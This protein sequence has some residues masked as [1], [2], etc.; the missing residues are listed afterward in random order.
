MPASNYL[1]GT[2]PD[3]VPSNAD[4]GEMA[5]QSKDAVEF[6]GG[7]GGLS[8]LDITAISAQ[9]NVTATDVFVYDTSK[10]SD[11]GAWRNRCQ[12][13][14]WFNEELN[15]ATRGARKDFPSVAVLVVDSTYLRIYDG[16]DPALPMWM[17]LQRGSTTHSYYTCSIFPD[18]GSLVSVVAMNGVIA[19]AQNGDQ[20]GCTLIK[21]LE[22]AAYTYPT[23]YWGYGVFKGNIAQRATYPGYHTLEAGKLLVGTGTDVAI[24]VLPNAP[25][26]AATGLP[27]PTIAVATTGGVSVI[28]HDGGVINKSG[29]NYLRVTSYGNYYIAKDGGDAL[30][31]HLWTDTETSINYF[32]G[33]SKYNG[34]IAT[35]YFPYLYGNG[36]LTAQA[37]DKTFAYAAS[38]NGLQLYSESGSSDRFTMTAAI[39]TNFNTG[40]MPGDIKG[41]WLCDTFPETLIGTEL[42]SYGDFSSSSGW[43][44]DANIAITG[45]VAVYSSPAHG[46]NLKQ[47][48]TQ[49]VSGKTYIIRFTVTAFTSGRLTLYA[50]Y[51]TGTTQLISS[52]AGGGV[53]S[54]FYT[55]TAVSS[56]TGFSL[57]ADSSSAGSCSMTIDNVSIYQADADRSS[58]NKGLQVF[59]SITKTPVAAGADL[60]SYSGF[61]ASNYLAQ[62]YNSAL[63]FGTGSFSFICW[64][65]FQ[66]AGGGTQF[67][68]RGNLSSGLAI[69]S[70]AD[71]QYVAVY[72]GG[73]QSV[74][75]NGLYQNNVW[76]Q[77]V[78]Q[79]I[80]GTV[81][82]YIN[83]RSV[84]QSF[85]L[86]NASGSTP[87]TYSDV[88]GYGS[89]RFALMRLSSTTLSE[90]QIVKIYE[91]EKLLFQDNA[92]ATLY[93]T[94]DS[95][96][97]LA[98]DEG[99]QL[100][101][102]GTSS[103][104]S[105][106]DG[107]R[108]V[109]NT[110]TAVS[111]TISAAN[112]L[113]VEN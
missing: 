68:T 45:G 28:K 69:W 92:K 105:V 26:D 77:L 86:A 103:G 63:D 88:T 109:D 74:T 40:W 10:D 25:V 36:G 107:L 102:V 53:G 78:V 6:T 98:Y 2:A 108:R 7:K 55:W 4:L 84:H 66:S 96:T 12:H 89:P 21:L 51:S 35:G 60:V 70:A 106:F 22:D 48:S 1:V 39:K 79:R 24:T 20:K 18:A 94:S 61:S 16:D 9:L 56:G 8:Q 100:L 83:G 93:G 91:D 82:I 42:V 59:G 5:F 101:H 31:V 27:I 62:P 95:V 19:V 90:A 33:S 110:T 29:G 85:N 67:I 34:N 50:N 38:P 15:T 44:I 111:A 23:V 80:N 43:T 52:Q 14:S 64:F 81:G 97:A 104:R 72:I 11:G 113:V 58:N 32:T 37:G 73:Q 99:T 76:N 3:Q 75:G 46:N 71:L 65:N 54:Y 112:G 57:Q 47:T 30:T 41:A 87:A 49:F 17:V 13:T